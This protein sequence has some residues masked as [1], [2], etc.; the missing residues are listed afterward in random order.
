MK[1]VLDESSLFLDLVLA[2]LGVFGGFLYFSHRILLVPGLYV[3]QWNVRLKDLAII[4]FVSRLSNHVSRLLPSNTYTELEFEQHLHYLR[5]YNHASQSRHPGGM[6]AP[7]RPLG[8]PQQL[9]VGLS[10][11]VVDKCHVL[12]RLYYR[13]ELQLRAPGEDLEQANRWSLCQ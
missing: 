7:L 10:H 12:Y 9:L 6:D 3:H 11:Y 4:L 1:A 8:H 2:A 13:R 5:C